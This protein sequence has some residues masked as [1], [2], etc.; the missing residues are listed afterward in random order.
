[1]PKLK[2]ARLYQ[3]GA[4]FIYNMFRFVQKMNEGGRWELGDQALG[5]GH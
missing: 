4:L 1:M 3:S 2:Q 5:I